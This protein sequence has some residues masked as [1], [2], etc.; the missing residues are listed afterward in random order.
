M[1]RAGSPKSGAAGPKKGMP[2]LRLVTTAACAGQSSPYA[3]QL[4]PS[5]QAAFLP[6]KPSSL[7][8][9]KHLHSHLSTMS[10][11]TSRNSLHLEPPR[12]SIELIDSGAHE[13]KFRSSIP[14]FM[15][16][17]LTLNLVS[18]EGEEEYF[19]DASE[20]RKRS[21]PVTPVSPIPKTR[22]EKIDD[23]P[24]YGEVPGTPAYVKRITDAVPDEVEIISPGRLSK[25]SSQIIEPP[26]SPGGTLIPRT[27]VEKV[28]P[29]SA[30][31]GEVPGTSA[32][33]QRQMDA[34]P[35]VILK[36]P[37]P[38]KRRVFTDEDEGN[39][40]RSVSNV[41]IPE[42]VITRVDTIPTHGEEPGTEVHKKRALNA[43][44]D[45]LENEGNGSG[46]SCV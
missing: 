45:F 12:K 37:E 30:S 22:I 26:R 27:V 46:K 7:L 28:D 40:D 39:R 32:Y 11:P 36:T 20:G 42:T 21:R 3:L 44:P 15:M 17:Q 23:D 2:T 1:R 18:S 41:S 5:S 29:D 10:R 34:A 6:A 43:A 13:R 33:I 8:G 31:Y 19:S 9:D 4:F 38:G 25:R 14:S 35:D 16:T 24:S